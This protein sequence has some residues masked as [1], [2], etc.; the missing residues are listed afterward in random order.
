MDFSPDPKQQL[1]V[2]VKKR[3]SQS[4]LVICWADI[5]PATMSFYV[6]YE[7]HEYGDPVV[8]RQSYE[9]SAYCLKFPRLELWVDAPSTS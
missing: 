9:G 4:L 7:I 3:K 8:D 2:F 1:Y 6:D 5:E